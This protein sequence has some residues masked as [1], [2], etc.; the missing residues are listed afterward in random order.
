MLVTSGGFGRIENKSKFFRLYQ[1]ISSGPAR[2]W[3]KSKGATWVSLFGGS[4]QITDDNIDAC[5][6]ALAWDLHYKAKIPAG[7]G[8]HLVDPA[9]SELKRSSK[10]STC[11]WDFDPC[12]VDRR[13]SVSDMV[14]VARESV[15]PSLNFSFPQSSLPDPGTPALIVMMA[16]QRN[17]ETGEIQ[18]V[19]KQ[20]AYMSCSK[21]KVKTRLPDAA[22]EGGHVWCCPTCNLKFDVDTCAPLN[23][24]VL[25]AKRI[26]MYKSGAHF[27]VPCGTGPYITPAQSLLMTG[28]SDALLKKT[29][30]VPMEEA[31]FDASVCTGSGLRMA[32]APKV[33]LCDECGGSSAKKKRKKRR[34][35]AG[36]DDESSDGAGCSVCA[37]LG[38]IT[39]WRCYWPVA[40]MDVRGQLLPEPLAA[41][42]DG[43][44]GKYK[45][46][47]CTSIRPPAH[48]KQTQGF[49][50]AA[51]RS[52]RPPMPEPAPSMLGE[53]LLFKHK[54]G[55]HECAVLADA[56][57][58]LKKRKRAREA[59]YPASASAALSEAAGVTRRSFDPTS[60]EVTLA[61]REIAA[62]SS[63]YKDAVIEKMERYGSTVCARLTSFGSRMCANAKDRVHGHGKSNV[64]FVFRF[65]RARGC[66][67]QQRC[68]STSKGPTNMPCTVYCKKH[69]EWKN[70]A[71]Q[72]L[73]MKLFPDMA[74]GKNLSTIGVAHDTRGRTNTVGTS[75]M[76][77]WS[78]GLD[79]V[80][81]ELGDL[82]WVRKF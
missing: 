9:F 36:G 24:D 20:T 45:T 68:Q 3:G 12:L 55:E 28:Y 47:R 48:A 30:I 4:Y 31:E 65:T 50:E 78:V 23:G 43:E 76:R 5:R 25:G 16:A 18:E 11:I 10:L 19:Y 7:R 35:T 15:L 79:L 54:T 59:A 60:K 27:R 29:G 67:L 32:Y 52:A 39:D 80:H 44:L 42:Q 14:R 66:Q 64:F 46:L 53:A 56:S 70:V 62:Y 38:K 69:C 1:R 82:D 6:K 61:M 51:L 37:G 26:V 74:G 2:Q 71:S 41:L 22:F 75:M 73:A 77:L 63:H 81:Q 72:E 17:P 13:L 8:G 40:V 34:D 57:N 49:R 58:I 21:C 33:K